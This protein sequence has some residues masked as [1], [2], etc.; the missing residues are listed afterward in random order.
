MKKIIICILLVVFLCSCSTST[1]SLDQS[2]MYQSSNTYSNLNDQNSISKTVENSKIEF[3]LKSNRSYEVF[4]GN[5]TDN[6]FDQVIIENP[7]DQKMYAEL[8]TAD[9]SGTRESQVFFDFYVK[10]WQKELTF[11]MENLKTYLSAEEAEKL[12]TAQSYWEE[13]WKSNS[14]FDK[15]LIGEKGIDL[16]TQSVPSGLIDLIDQYRDRVFH[17]KY[18]TLL[19]EEYVENPIPSNRCLWK[20]FSIE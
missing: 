11:S 15:F 4:E 19:V 12:D 9:I 3:P 14:E 16:G 8:K 1:L 20:K 18:M 10:I 13:S 17:I 7:I 2:T 6:E 5:S